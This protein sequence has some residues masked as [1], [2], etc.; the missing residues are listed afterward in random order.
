MLFIAELASYGVATIIFANKIYNAHISRKVFIW[1]HVLC[2]LLLALCNFYCDHVTFVLAFSL[3][4][5]LQLIL[6]KFSIQDLRFSS[7]FGTFFILYSLNVIITFSVKCV[8][9]LTSEQGIYIEA[10]FSVLILLGC[11]IL[12]F[13]PKLSS[14]TRQIICSLPR[15]VKV[16]TTLAFGTNALL[17]PLFFSNP[18]LNDNS[19]WSLLARIL[20]FVLSLFI[21][22][23]FPILLITT[24]TNIHLR[25]QTIDFEHNL[26]IQADH[27][28]ALAKSNFELRR[29][30]HDFKNVKI[31]LSKYIEQ[32]DI[33]SA[34]ALL[35]S[36][37]DTMHAAEDI[38]PFDCGNGIIDALLADKQTKAL[39]KNISIRFDGAIPS[40]SKLAPIDLCVIF[41]NTIDNAVE[42]CEQ[43][44]AE[45]E[46]VI[47]ISAQCSCG[48]LFIKIQNP[49]ATP[50]V[51]RNN[52]ITTT[53]NDRSAHGFGLY[54]LE[55]TIKKYDGTIKL[56]YENYIFTLEITL[57][58]C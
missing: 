25:R 2:Y 15:K 55:Q 5:V 57:P 48:F 46:K 43:L 56:S 33:P 37:E 21:C 30:R 9:N 23:L 18:I 44:P 32:Q 34:L 7:I 20:L 38:L 27:Y 29:F 26:Q 22:T 6:I 53:K 51:I 13:H 50:V 1:I 41:G 31:G 49:T 28:A 16:L 40:L 17:L 54:S 8:G 19:A 11:L 45:Q 39:D 52:M 10:L 14:T 3:L 58:L 42:A 24:I 4:L 35:E 47:Q 12:C 36:G